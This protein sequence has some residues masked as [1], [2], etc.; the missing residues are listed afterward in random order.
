MKE[1]REPPV[2]VLQK[3]LSAASFHLKRSPCIV[4]QTYEQTGV[5]S[6]SKTCRLLNR[7]V[8]KSP[9]SVQQCSKYARLWNIGS[10]IHQE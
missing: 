5:R 1:Y 8:K 6:P 7:H 10:G 9:R 2:G 3:M 4:N